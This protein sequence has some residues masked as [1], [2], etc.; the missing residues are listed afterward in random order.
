MA[1]CSQCNKSETRDRALKLTIK[2]LLEDDKV[3][4]NATNCRGETALMIAAG[5]TREVGIWFKEGGTGRDGGE[6]VR[7]SKRLRYRDLNVT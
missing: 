6:G 1:A 4:V 7:W 2:R 5:S 3:L